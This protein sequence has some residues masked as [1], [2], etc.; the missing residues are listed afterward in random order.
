MDKN[1]N[2]KP[3]SVVPSGEGRIGLDIGTSKILNV[4]RSRATS[5]KPSP[6]RTLSSTFPIHA[7]LRTFCSRTRST[8]IN[9]MVSSLST[10]TA[11]RNS[12]AS[13]TLLRVAL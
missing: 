7:S 4:R 9:Q 6:R 11:R 2:P 3:E 8:T 5:S 10:G 1:P 12:P 13:S